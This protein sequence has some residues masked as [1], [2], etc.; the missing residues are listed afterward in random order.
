MNCEKAMELLDFLKTCVRCGEILM[1]SN[2]C[3]NCKFQNTCE[4]ALPL[5][6]M[7]RI[8]CH[9]WEERK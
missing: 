7:V 9:L 6:E 4:Y 5:G 1:N 8:N 3:N 2:T